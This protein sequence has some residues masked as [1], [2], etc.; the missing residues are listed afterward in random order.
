LF[1]EGQYT[2]KTFWKGEEEEHKKS[3]G[4]REQMCVGYL[5]RD[6]TGS[7]PF[8]FFLFCL[9]SEPVSFVHCNRK[10]CRAFASPSLC[11]NNIYFFRCSGYL[12][13]PQLPLPLSSHPHFPHHWHISSSSNFFLLIF[14]IENF[15]YRQCRSKNIII[16]IDRVY[17]TASAASFSLSSSWGSNHQFTG[18]VQPRSQLICIIGIVCNLP[19]RT[20]ICAAYYHTRVQYCIRVLLPVLVF[21]PFIGI[22]Q[23]IVG[24]PTWDVETAFSRFSPTPEADRKRH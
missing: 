23:F 8:F 15:M 17:L 21:V 3:S 10:T 9:L 19:P 16:I 7:L 1:H 24:I 14:G 22:F 5:Q 2:D 4:T 12:I 20:F 13:S 11:H 6:L 18:Y